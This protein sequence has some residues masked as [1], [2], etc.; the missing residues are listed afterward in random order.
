MTENHM[1]R[2][3]RRRFFEESMIAAAAVAA[4]SPGPRLLAQEP[5]RAAPSEMIRHA[6]IGCRIRGRVHAAEF[7]RQDGV[8]VSYVCDP[9]QQ[10]AD[11]LAASVEMQQGRRPKAVQDLRE[12]LDDP[13]VDTVSIAAPNHWHALA[14]IWAMQAGK[15]VYVE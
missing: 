10:L 3:T 15:H 11:E 7:C 12:I 4:G 1:S 5:G 14:S 2:T 9:D 6:V 8:E 13:S